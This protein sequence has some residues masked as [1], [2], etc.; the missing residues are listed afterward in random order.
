MQ[1]DHTPREQWL[2]TNADLLL[3]GNTAMQELLPYVNT[4]VDAEQVRPLIV[5]L[6]VAVSE[7]TYSDFDRGGLSAMCARAGGDFRAGLAAMDAGDGP[8]AGECLS[9]GLAAY[10]GALGPLLGADD[11]HDPPRRRRW[12]WLVVGLILV[13]ALL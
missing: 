12:C 6:E 3:A 8:L 10:E 4:N 13:A 7:V 9:S 1:I 2:A 11:G 5:R